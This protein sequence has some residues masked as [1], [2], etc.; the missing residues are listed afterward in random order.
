MAKALVA[1]LTPV[2][3]PAP[4]KFQS[5]H[6]CGMVL[7]GR[8]NG[9]G[10]RHTGYKDELGGPSMGG[11]DHIGCSPLLLLLKSECR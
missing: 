7:Q 8:K 10:H 9:K 6:R 3:E 4:R 11:A 1:N 5:G 2:D